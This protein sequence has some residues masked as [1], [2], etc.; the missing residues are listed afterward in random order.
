MHRSLTTSQD[1]G[2][3]WVGVIPDIR[4]NIIFNHRKQKI[5]KQ[6]YKLSKAHRF[7]LNAN[8]SNHAHVHHYKLT[9]FGKSGY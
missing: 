9:R 6:K 2:Y 4:Q 5:V 1:F 8:T 7:G 3:L